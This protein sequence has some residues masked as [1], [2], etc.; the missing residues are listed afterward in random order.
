MGD[1]IDEGILISRRHSPDEITAAYYCLGDHDYEIPPQHA[2]RLARLF[3]IAV[4]DIPPASV[5][6]VG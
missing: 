2:E 4:T 1:F 5:I 3:G 6:I